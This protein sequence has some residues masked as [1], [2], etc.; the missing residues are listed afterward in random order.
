M[1]K[2]AI[3]GTGISGLAA[4]HVLHR[5]HD[6][7]VFEAQEYIGGHTNTVVVDDGGRSLAVDTGFIVY[8]TTTYPNLMRL[9]DELGVPTQESNMSFSLSCRETGFEYGNS[10]LSSLKARPRNLVSRD[11]LRMVYDHLRFSRDVQRDVDDPS[12]A[13]ARLGEYIREKKYSSSFVRYML[14]PMA[15]AIWSSPRRAIHD[16]PAQ[17]LFH[18]YINHGLLQG[19]QPVYWRTVSGGSHVYVKKL[20][21]PFRHKIHLNCAVRAVRRHEAH[22]S[23]ILE[24]GTE[25]VYDHVV[26]ATH[27]DQA[28]RLLA[29]PS[30]EEQAILGQIAYQRNTAVLH[31]DESVLPRHPAAWASWNYTLYAGQDADNPTSL[32]YWMNSLQKLD[33]NTNYCVTIN[34][35][36][37]NPDRIIKTI[38]YEHPVY[39]LQSLAAQKRLPQINGTRRTHYCGAYCGYGFHEDGMNAG[40]A[41]AQQLGASW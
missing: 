36:H 40:L 4:A 16:F 7:E 3:I 26:I 39:S 8:N 38:T 13:N 41:V 20:V 10:L 29:D 27:S 30:P 21:Q 12:Y 14:T 9:F 15:S 11:F 2:I 35:N 17:Y 1:F 32:T 31:T 22:V 23:L 34:P 6:I 25:K 28:L 37:I 5:V 19:S 33:T 18:F 24:D